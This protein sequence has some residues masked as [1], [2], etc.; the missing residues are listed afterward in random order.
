MRARN[1]VSWPHDCSR[2]AARS[3]GEERSAVVISLGADL[4]I[5]LPPAPTVVTVTAPAAAVSTPAA[6]LSLDTFAAAAPFG[7]ALVEGADPFDAQIVQSNAALA[8]MAG[9]GI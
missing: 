5:R 3:S 8:A 4:L 6:P 7:A 9:P 1:S 2:K